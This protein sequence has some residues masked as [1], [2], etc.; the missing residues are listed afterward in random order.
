MHGANIA[1]VSICGTDRK[2]TNSFSGVEVVSYSSAIA[3][4]NNYTAK[5]RTRPQFV[6]TT[7]NKEAIGELYRA[8]VFC[9]FNDTLGLVVWAFADEKRYKCECSYTEISET[10]LAEIGRPQFRNVVE[11]VLP[12]GF[13]GTCFEALIEKVVADDGGFDYRGT[14]FKIVNRPEL[15]PEFLSGSSAIQYGWV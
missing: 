4:S 8:L 5:I 14:N 12:E 10:E 7:S 9:S 11:I 1:W 3:L 6:S 15:S 13:H 2:T